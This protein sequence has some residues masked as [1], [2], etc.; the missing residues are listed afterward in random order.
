MPSRAANGKEFSKYWMHNAFLNIDNHKMSK[1]LG[2]FRTVREIS[3]Q[4]DLQVLRFFMLSAHYRSPLNFSA[5]LMEAS[6]S[7][8]ERIVNAADHLKFLTGNAKSETMTE[9]EKALFGKTGEFVEG[10]EHAMEDDFNTAD[11]VAAVFELVKYI[12]T[13]TDEGSS[14]E[15]L[16]KML[17]LLKKLTDVLGLI[18][19]RKEEILDSD[20]EE[21]IRERQEARK[22]K[23]FARADAIRDELLEKGIIL[24]DTREGVQWKRA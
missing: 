4:Y 21:L 20:I 9:A 6:K 10:F 5:D 17:D 14:K 18:V 24:K 15:Y 11:A 22:A 19:D 2:N 13:N 12:N 16:G 23:D 1:S 7:G 8:L 3:G